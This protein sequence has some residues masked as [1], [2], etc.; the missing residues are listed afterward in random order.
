VSQGDLLGLDELRRRRRLDW[1][2]RAAIAENARP[3]EDQGD[4]PG[5]AHYLATSNPAASTT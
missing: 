2:D 1:L 4:E 5:V 3:G